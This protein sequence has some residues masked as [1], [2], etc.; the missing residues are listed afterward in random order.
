MRPQVPQ[1]LLDGVVDH[2]DPLE[3]YLFGSRARGDEK[4][5]SDFDLLVV[6][7]DDAPAADISGRKLAQARSRYR[8]PV[9]ILVSRKSHFERR[10]TMLGALAEIVSREGVLVYEK[11]VA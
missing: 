5:D 1:A 8:G 3:V 10:R 6:V 2:L 9:D 7:R 4:A 11:P